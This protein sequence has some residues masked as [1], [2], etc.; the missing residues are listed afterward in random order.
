[1]W[2][3]G[4]RVMI[5]GASDG[6]PHGAKD[7]RNEVTLAKPNITGF[8]SGLRPQ[9]RDILT[10]FAGF[11]VRGWL[12][13]LAATVLTLAFIAIPTDIIANPIF[14]RMIPVRD[15]DYV[16]WALTGPLVGLIAGTYAMGASSSGQGGMFSGG[17]LSFLA[18][19]CPLCNK[20]VIVLLGT[21]GALSFFAPAQLFLG[22]AAVALLGVT[23]QLRV[24]ALTQACE[25]PGEE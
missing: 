3:V 17:F 6:P 8:L 11:G 10:V 12:L 9:R 14:R 22:I 18:V 23:L 1:M 5:R 16:F 21:S 13:A 25:L 4:A 2:R 19:G 24:R 7:D 20:L 15:Q